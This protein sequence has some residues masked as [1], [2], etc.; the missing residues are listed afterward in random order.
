SQDP[1]PRSS[2]PF[3]AAFLFFQNGNCLAPIE[4][5][6]RLMVVFGYRCQCSFTILLRPGLLASTIAPTFPLQPHKETLR[7][8]MHSLNW[9]AILVAA[10]SI[11]IL[12]FFWY[13]LL[14]FAKAWMR[15]MGYDPN[16]KAKMEEMR[17]SAGPT[18]AN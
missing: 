8:Y 12:G 9:L 2:F 10:I 5:G 14:L 15:E 6:L 4:K 3:K 11:M 13:S 1:S 18:Y 17:K 7:M 16:D